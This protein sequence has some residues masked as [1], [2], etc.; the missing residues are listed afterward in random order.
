MVKTVSELNSLEQNKPS[1]ADINKHCRVK[2][3]NEFDSVK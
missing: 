3:H 1:G 2:N